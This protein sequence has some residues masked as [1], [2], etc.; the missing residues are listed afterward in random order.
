MG[1]SKKIEGGAGITTFVAGIALCTVPSE[2][3]RAV[4]AALVFVGGGLMKRA[5]S[6]SEE[7]QTSQENQSTT[8][9]RIIRRRL[10]N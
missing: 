7:P 4:G 3:I 8:P 5:V 9:T 2:R 1:F 10:R 6:L